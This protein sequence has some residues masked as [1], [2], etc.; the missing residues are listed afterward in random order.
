[1]FIGHFAVGFSAKKVA[2][3]INLGTL[4]FAA[5][6]LDLIWPVLI[7]T[8]LEHVRIRPDALPFLRLDLYDYPYSHSLITSLVWSILIGLIYY[9]LKKSARNSFIIGG[10]VFSHWLLD[11]ISHAPD[12]PLAPGL[13]P[14]V[15]LGLWNS[16]LATVIV[17]SALFFFGIFLYVHTTKAKN[18][19]GSISLWALILFLAIC[20]VASTFGPPPPD[21]GPIGWMGLSMWLLIPW[22]YWIDRNRE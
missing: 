11:F 10:A 13:S 4:F 2:P 6:F 3:R 18:N 9:L 16:T 8:G 14:V 7:I 21:A 5:Q 19:I 1:M 22:G 17:E 12:L 20:Y 15:G